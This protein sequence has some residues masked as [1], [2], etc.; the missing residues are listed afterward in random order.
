MPEKVLDAVEQV[1][2]KAQT[3][4]SAKDLAQEIMSLGL[5]S[6]KGKTPDATIGAYLA[7]DIK[8]NGRRSRF[9]R[10]SPG[11]FALHGERQE[12]AARQTRPR[13]AR[14]SPTA[15]KLGVK[16]VR[17][18]A[19]EI[20]GANPEG[21][22]YGE[23]VAAILDRAP[24]TPRNTIAGSMWNLDALYPKLVVKPTRGFF[25][26]AGN[27]SAALS[28]VRAERVKEESFYE[29]FAEWLKNDLGEVTD[30]IALGGSCLRGKWGTP[31]V[32]GVYKP[33]P[34]DRIRWDLEVIAAEIKIAQDPVVAFG[35]AAVYRL[36]ATKTYV[37]MP[38]SIKEDLD[39]LE[40]LCMLYGVGLVLFQVDL[41]NPRFT[42]RVRAQR[43]SPDMYFVNDFADS[44]HRH[45]REK[46]NRLF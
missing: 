18:L 25:R 9:C 40:A 36:F 1:L 35:Q 2:Q 21:I 32:I 33:R 8:R 37:V 30:A 28:E 42:I 19:L 6:T 38:D 12:P 31:D 16:D 4:L 46:F 14:R 13:R 11:M 27:S 7:M 17:D 3:S 44:L 29:P 41:Q 23:L 39:R 26:P 5:W 45:D 15:T 10:T 34:S 24:R 20:V 22:R 43:F